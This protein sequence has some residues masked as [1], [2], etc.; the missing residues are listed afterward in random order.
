MEERD[1]DYFRGILTQSLKDLLRKGDEA[2]SFFW[3]QRWIRPI[4][5]IK[6]PLKQTGALGFE[7]ET[8]KTN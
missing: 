3:N 2:V 5:S 1:L 6:P 7:C 8:G 4:L